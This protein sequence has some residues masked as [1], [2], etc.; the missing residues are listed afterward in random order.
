MSDKKF[1][2]L[3]TGKSLIILSLV[4]LSIL[5][6]GLVLSSLHILQF[7]LLLLLLLFN[8]FNIILFYFKIVITIGSSSLDL[9]GVVADFIV[10]TNC[11]NSFQHF[12][13]SFKISLYPVPV[14]ILFKP[15]IYILTCHI[16]EDMD[17]QTSGIAG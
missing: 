13:M 6:C 3:K 2:I 12:A 11:F 10:F 14:N 16:D 8:S 7:N 4:I 9:N 15:G 5:L 1:T 17:G